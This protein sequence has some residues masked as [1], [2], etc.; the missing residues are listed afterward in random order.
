MAKKARIIRKIE[1]RDGRIVA[2]DSQ[3]IANAIAKAGKDSGELKKAPVRE[4]SG[5]V[6]SLLLKRG[7]NGEIPTVEEVQ[8]VVEE[9]LMREGC[10]KTAK[11]YILYREQHKV[12]REFKG[13]D[14][15]KLIG[16][17]LK[18]L[19]WRVRENANMAFSIQGLNNHVA[20][21]ISSQYWLN[22]IYPPKIRKTH[23]EADFH[24]HNL[25]LLAPYCCGWD[26]KDL[27]IR[28]FGGVPGKVE[29]RPP[30][31]FRVALGQVV[32][33]LYTVQGEIAGAVAVSNFDT[34]LAPFV[35]YDRLDYA[36]VKQM[37]QEFLYWMNV[38]TRVGFQTPFSN[39]TFDLTPPGDMA[40][41][42]VIIGGT[43][44]KESY[45]EFQKEMGMIN[46]A[47]A[48]VMMEGD[49]KGR[50]FTFPI[51]TYNV[52]KNFNWDDPSLEP[53]W[54]MTAR[55]GVPYFANFI[56]SD[57]KPEDIRSMC[58]RL[59]LDLS[60]LEHRGGSLFA[61][62]PLTG[63][64]GVVT[65]NMARIGFL[66]QSP[67]ASLGQAKKEFLTRLGSLVDL[68]KES[69]E[70]KRTTM[71]YFTE[72]GL[73]PY[74]R[75]YLDM[76][77]ERFG[78][79]WANHFSTIGL[80][81]V[82]EA[83]VNFMGEDI[84]SKKGRKFALEILDFV[85]DKLL[86]YQ[87]ETGNFYNLEATPAES[88][89]YVFAKED[90]KRFPKV[91]VANEEA[92]QRGADPFYS[93][94]T[95][96]PVSFTDDLFEALD[97]QDELQSKYTGGTVLHGFLGESLPSGEAVK[98]LVKKVV[99]NY[100]LPYFTVTPTFSICAEHGY[101]RGEHPFCP[102]CKRPAEVFS[103]VV[104]YL[105]PVGQWNLGKQAEF[106]ERKEYSVQDG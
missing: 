104:G 73:F 81:G 60:Q 49:A 101:L 86:E 88:T 47:F 55:Y 36:Q 74:A 30:G 1:K 22:K 99:G 20:S 84:A 10:H 37:M 94:S 97:L 7:F 63:S 64:I 59:R 35:A 85:L 50:V 15:D 27:L 13:I 70:I 102:H 43:P 82:N 61:S 16:D 44:Q 4:L 66:S 34:L 83:L 9:I 28:G 65:I 79:Y 11:A 67:S 18:E 45:G 8:D 19:D 39:I 29:S 3:K 93:N 54:E 48:E 92:Y 46:K 42:P 77:K 5:T 51:P 6:V 53:I 31:I 62:N 40:S 24:I 26:L 75:H 57:M 17:Y 41:E 90:K 52:T 95:H 72:I 89:A 14:S 76:V 23:L 106:E 32:N 91:V 98:N 71:E 87:E 38:P 25:Q 56:S 100:K 103:R 69:L 21:T 80:N 78:S 12:L 58:C 68:A 105:R 96:L 33:F 2:F